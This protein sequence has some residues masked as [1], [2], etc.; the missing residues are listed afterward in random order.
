MGRPKGDPTLAQF[1]ESAD[2]R[3]P[4]LGLC[5]VGCERLCRKL[6]HSRF[7]AFDQLCQ[8]DELPVWKFQRVMMRSRFILVDLPENGRR[9]I[10]YTHVQA[11]QPARPA[12]YLLGKG[13]LR[14]RKNANGRSSIF[15]RSEPASSGIEIAGGQLVANLSRT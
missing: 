10:D 2:M 14:S 13:E 8:E 1:G 6:K 4:F 11:K 15:R 3:D 7:L 9:V 12:P 5:L